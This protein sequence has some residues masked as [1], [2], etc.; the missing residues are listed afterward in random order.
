MNWA[1]VSVD[2]DDDCEVMLIVQEVPAGVGTS[3]IRKV[4]QE[5]GY[6]FVKRPG[7]SLFFVSEPFWPQ[8]V[9]EGVM[10]INWASLPAQRRIQT[11]IRLEPEEL[12]I[13]REAA[14]R[15]GLS[16]ND[17]MVGTLLD[18]AKRELDIP[19]PRR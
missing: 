18:V 8:P 10:R 9:P 11:T 7:A 5:A 17:W 4:L 3:Q 14:A 16:M 19:E 13:V 6:D 1:V 12:A 2:R 15:T